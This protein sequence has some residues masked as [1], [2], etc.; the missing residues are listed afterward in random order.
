MTIHDVELFPDDRMLRMSRWDNKR[1]REHCIKRDGPRCHY[2]GAAFTEYVRTHPHTRGKRPNVT[3]VN[4][5]NI[6]IDHVVP[7]NPGLTTPFEEWGADV[8]KNWVVACHECNTSKGKKD[9]NEWLKTRPTGCD[10]G[11]SKC[12]RGKAVPRWMAKAF[13][14]YAIWTSER[15]P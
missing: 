15:L 3:H 14:Q 5:R 11:Q 2:C 10:C 9:V 4:R 6:A 13:A 12:K 7:L 8:P 1:K